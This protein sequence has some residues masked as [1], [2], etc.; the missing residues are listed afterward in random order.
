MTGDFYFTGPIKV[1]IS[2]E[3]TKS[4]SKSKMEAL[5]WQSIMNDNDPAVF[6]SY[7][8]KYPDGEF[9]DL[10]KIKIS[11]LKK[12]QK[13]EILPSLEQPVQ[14]D[15]KKA[16]GH[17]K[18]TSDPPGASVL[19]DGSPLGNTDM[20]ASNIEP[21]KRKIEI[22]KD[23][24]KLKTAEVLIKAGQQVSMNLKLEPSCGGISATS[25]PTGADIL[26]DN[27]PVGITP[28]EVM[29][30]SEGKHQITIRKD[31]FHDWQEGIVVKTG[32]APSLHAVLSK[33]TKS[34]SPE[35][36]PPNGVNP[37]V[38]KIRT[39]APVSATYAIK[40]AQDT[41]NV[42]SRML[43]CWVTRWGG[44]LASQ[45]IIMSTSGSIAEGYYS[46]GDYRSIQKGWMRFRATIVEPGILHWGN[47]PYWKIILD[48]E[49][50][51][52]QGTYTKTKS[53]GKDF[54]IKGLFQHPDVYKE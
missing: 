46:W 17:L 13:N 9:S 37:S 12:G 29:G 50:D 54:V 44:Y 4:D 40:E 31:A 21:G 8:K 49:S 53:D 30:I 41:D 34:T 27:K 42:T 6:E 20:D 7:L 32:N 22:Q 15:S 33:N 2:Q 14:S 1:E 3:P 38:D 28:A 45:L 25:D 10:A 51:S 11:N 23:C 43:G 48:K 26:I 19:L 39:E 16:Y 52:I 35:C 5:Y 24:F 18:L 47:D 36:F